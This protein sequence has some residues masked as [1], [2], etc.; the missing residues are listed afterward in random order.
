[1]PMQPMMFM[2]SLSVLGR[3]RRSSMGLY[4]KQAMRIHERDGSLLPLSQA[5]SAHGTRC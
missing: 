3:A 2:P 5:A 1:M 4:L